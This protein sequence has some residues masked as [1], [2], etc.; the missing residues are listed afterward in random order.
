MHLTNTR[1]MALQQLSLLDQWARHCSLKIWYWWTRNPKKELATFLFFSYGTYCRIVHKKKI[2]RSK[3]Q[4]AVDL[5]K[6]KKLFVSWCNC[7]LLLLLSSSLSSPFWVERNYGFSNFVNNS[8]AI[9][10]GTQCVAS[11]SPAGLANTVL[12]PNVVATCLFFSWQ[13]PKPERF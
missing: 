4:S 2:S 1:N 6:A 11:L 12:S 13:S 3:V 8:F 9:E 7:G 5:I 10:Q